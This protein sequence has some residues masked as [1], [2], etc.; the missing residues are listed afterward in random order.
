MQLRWRI[1][2]LIRDTL[3]DSAVAWLRKSF[4]EAVWVLP[5]RL[6]LKLLYLK[7]HRRWPDF[8]N[9]KA[10]SEKVAAA[11]LLDPPYEHLADK[12]KVK[13]WV[14][15][16][17]GAEY[18]IPTLWSG[19]S[20]PPREERNWPLPFVIKANNGSGGHIFVEDDPDWPA[21]EER[22]EAL[23]A[24]DYGKQTHEYFYSR[25]DPMIMV[26][27]KIGNG[28][29]PIDYKYFTFGGRVPLFTVTTERHL[30]RKETFFYPDGRRAKVDMGQPHDPNVGERAPK[31]SLDMIPIVERLAEGLPFARVDFYFEDGKALFGEM[32]LMCGAGLIRVNPPEVDFDL[33]KAWDG[34]ST[35]QLAREGR[36][37]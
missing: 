13:A 33:G 31:E 25:I 26:E 17:I 2:R 5:D 10:Y 9:P 35:L 37:C 30:G 4:D 21:I 20:L 6:A 3:P 11:R 15:D 22:V 12:V 29:L 18:L 1:L 36:I 34:D 28:V 8:D 32:T 19:K 14:A 27:P 23:L 24:C 7:S 16:R